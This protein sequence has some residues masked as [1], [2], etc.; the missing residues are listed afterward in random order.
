MS[1]IHL[2]AV[3]TIVSQI[4]NE[5]VMIDLILTLTEDHRA[6]LLQMGCQ[7]PLCFMYV[8]H[9]EAVTVIVKEICDETVII[10][11]F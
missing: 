8:I 6:K 5:K 4:F 2:K 10:D 1:V 11:L 7:S 9:V 3:T